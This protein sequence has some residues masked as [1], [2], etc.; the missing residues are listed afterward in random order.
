MQKTKDFK[1]INMTSV[2]VLDAK[3]IQR[4]VNVQG[5]ESTS[6]LVHAPSWTCCVFS[7]KRIV[8]AWTRCFFSLIKELYMQVF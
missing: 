8:H 4:D 5:V 7:Y 6:H 1:Q 2:F 3:L